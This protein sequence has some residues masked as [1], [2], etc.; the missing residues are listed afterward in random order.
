[1]P[2]LIVFPPKLNISGTIVQTDH[3]KGPWH[4]RFSKSC[5]MTFIV[6]LSASTQDLEA[7]VPGSV[8]A[9]EEHNLCRLALS[10][11]R[12]GVEIDYVPTL[13]RD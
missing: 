13:V 4:S 1:M 5:S 2:G 7:L 12:V 6:T 9:L 8:E 10:A 3:H 11:R